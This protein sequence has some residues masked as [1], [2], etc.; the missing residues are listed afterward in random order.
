MRQGRLQTEK[1]RYNDCSQQ[2]NYLAEESGALKVMVS[3]LMAENLSTCLQIQLCLMMETV[4][5]DAGG[6]LC[7]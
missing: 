4:E 6:S 7:P 3:S 2:V 5:D 1:F